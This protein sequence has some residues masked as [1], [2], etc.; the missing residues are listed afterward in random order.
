MEDYECYIDYLYI[1]L[2]VLFQN[3]VVQLI[4]FL[5]WEVQNYGYFEN[6]IISVYYLVYCYIVYGL[7]KNV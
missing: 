1:F 2:N 5:D 6:L 3:Q 7:D 4:F